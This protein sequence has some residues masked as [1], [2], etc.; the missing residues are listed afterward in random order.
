M[1]MN[2]VVY[3]TGAPATGKTS[4]AEYLLATYGGRRFSYGEAL[5]Q[6]PTLG[7]FSHED[8]RTHSSR[9]VTEGMIQALDRELPGIIDTWRSDGPVIIDSHAVTSEMYGLR[10]IPYSPTSLA[11]LGISH[12]V[13]L[14]CDPELLLAR[15]QARPD[16]RRQESP[17][18]LDQMNSAQVSLAVA[19]AHTLGVPVHLV[20]ARETLERV[21]AAV[22]MCCGLTAAA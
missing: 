2:P 19:Y 11:A 5:I 4:V 7:K 3:L 15:I 18:K 9:I 1:R 17:W 6:E 10:A 13:C 8:L 21:Q 20:D 12:V 22:A 16:G 14:T